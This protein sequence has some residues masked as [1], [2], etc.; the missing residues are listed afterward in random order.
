MTTHAKVSDYQDPRFPNSKIILISKD[1][2]KHIAAVNWQMETAKKGD[3]YDEAYAFMKGFL[4]EYEDFKLLTAREYFRFIA[5]LDMHEDNDLANRI[6]KQPAHNIGTL[7]HYNKKGSH[8]YLNVI[9]NF[10]Q[11]ITSDELSKMVKNAREQNIPQGLLPVSKQQKRIFDGLEKL[12]LEKYM[13]TIPEEPA[14]YSIKISDLD[15]KGTYNAS[16][17]ENTNDL[18]TKGD[19]AKIIITASGVRN[20]S[21]IKSSYELGNDAEPG[22]VLSY[23][24]NLSPSYMNLEEASSHKGP[25]PNGA[26]QLF[27]V[28]A[29]SKNAYTILNT[30]GLGAPFNELNHHPFFCAHKDILN[31]L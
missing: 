27:E 5:T 20:Y 12:T 6:F 13:L 31:R 3:T 1:D 19:V 25:L 17:I 24:Q 15:E 30:D 23:L 26:I 10:D 21:S 18:Q 9:N 16:T 29:D 11:I 28:E 2:S 8:V 4:E 14:M 22:I 7:L